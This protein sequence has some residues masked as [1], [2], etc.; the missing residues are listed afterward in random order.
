MKGIQ[1]RLQFD[2]FIHFSVSLDRLHQIES[3]EPDCAIF[4]KFFA[5]HFLVLTE[6]FG[7]ESIVF[8]R[9][10][11][12]EWA[13]GLLGSLLLCGYDIDSFRIPSG[14]GALPH[15]SKV[16]LRHVTGHEFLGRET[17]S[18]FPLWNVSGI[19]RS[20]FR[21]LDGAAE[22]RGKSLSGGRRGEAENGGG[23]GSQS[24]SCDRKFHFADFVRFS[25]NISMCVVVSWIERD[26]NA[27][28]LSIR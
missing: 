7:S 18:V 22:S 3:P 11:N 9:G 2:S 5:D 10:T 19:W 21:W 6:I 20:S 17:S 14:Q 1:A 27:P 12:F 16:G 4:Q 28:S 23:R 25:S 26:P 24:K 13:V 8:G 15:T